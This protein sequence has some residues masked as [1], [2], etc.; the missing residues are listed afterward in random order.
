M[1]LLRRERN[2]EKPSHDSREAPVCEHTVL[3]PRWDRAEDVGREKAATAYRCEACGAEFTPDEALHLRATE[4]AR[5]Q[6]RVSA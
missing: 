5:V 1:R 2:Q 4:S 3:V 6:R